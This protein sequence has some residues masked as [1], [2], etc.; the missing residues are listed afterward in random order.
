MASVPLRWNRPFAN[1]FL[2]AVIAALCVVVCGS[3][4]LPT[5]NDAAVIALPANAMASLALTALFN[6]GASTPAHWSFR[7]CQGY[8]PRWP[9]SALRWDCLRDPLPLQQ[10]RHLL[11]VHDA[12]V[13]RRC[14]AR[15]GLVLL[16]HRA[17]LDLLG[18]RRQD[19]LPRSEALL[20]PALHFRVRHVRGH[21]PD[22]VFSGC[23]PCLRERAVRS[24]GPG[25]ASVENHRHRL[26]IPIQFS[27]Q[28]AM[29]FQIAD[30][31]R[32]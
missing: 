15:P 14:P 1:V 26:S 27:D 20:E 12:G 19:L 23:A 2:N 21:G 32:L 17:L 24:P 18:R 28:L 22:P 10:R 25:A 7:L 9:S 8:S 16:L 5:F 31:A 3:T 13:E 6:P 4:I 29:G 11:V 30:Q